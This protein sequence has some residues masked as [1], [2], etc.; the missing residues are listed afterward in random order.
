[1]TRCN[2]LDNARGDISHE[3]I[4]A[5]KYNWKEPVEPKEPPSDHIDFDTKWCNW[6]KRI[7]DQIYSREFKN[8]PTYKPEIF[9]FMME[10]LD[11]DVWSK[12]Q[13]GAEAPAKTASTTIEMHQKYI[14]GVKW[15]ELR[16]KMVAK[17]KE[18]AASVGKDEHSWFYNHEL[19]RIEDAVLK[20]QMEASPVHEA[21]AEKEEM[22]AL[23]DRLSWWPWWNR[24]F[25]KVS[26]YETH[27]YKR[28]VFLA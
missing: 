13:K 18:F 27:G 26:E 20:R 15:F 23:E 14:D 22:K 10:A 25:T 8:D 11:K 21:Q 7:R 4:M 17:L 19:G 3:I 2:A 5:G 24:E 28:F 9:K 1:M 12:I 16:K 6:R